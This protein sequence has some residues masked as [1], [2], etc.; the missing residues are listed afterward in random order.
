MK[1]RVNEIV[2]F[3]SEIFKWFFG[4]ILKSKYK[5]DSEKLENRVIKI[6][7]ELNLINEKKNV[8]KNKK[9]V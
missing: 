5:D 7:E 6:K 9:T 1:Q 3:I 2:A 4:N 8:L